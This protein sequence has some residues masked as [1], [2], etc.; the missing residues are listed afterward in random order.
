[1]SFLSVAQEGQKGHIQGFVLVAQSNEKIPFCHIK[2]IESGDQFI[3]DENGFFKT[4]ILSFGEYHFVI[5]NVGY[6]LDTLSILLS[7]P[8]LKHNIE[9]APIFYTIGPHTVVANKQ[10]VGA[11]GR[12]KPIEGVMIAQGKKADVI[13]LSYVAGN[14]ATNNA[15]QIYSSIPGLNIWESDGAGIQLGI[16][17]RGLSPSRTA[18]YN[19]RQNGYD[20]SA[21]A[22]GY[23]ES[24]YTPPSQAI[25]Q[26]QFIK[27]AGSLQYGPQF[28]GV[29]NFKLKKGNRYRPFS[30]SYQKTF[31]SFGVNT[32][33]LEVGGKKKRVQYYG[34]FNWKKGNEWRPNSAYE[35]ITAG[36]NIHYYITENSLINFEFTK[37]SYLAQQPGGLT[38]YEFNTTPFISKRERNWFQVDWNLWSINHKHS[39][40]SKNILNTKV[41]GLIAS[42]KAL[43]FLGQ[44]NRVDPMQ[45]RNLIVGNFNNIGVESKYLKLYDINEIPQALLMGVRLYRGNSTGQQGFGTSS[46]SPDFYFINHTELEF[47]DYSFP[48]KNAAIFVENIFRLNEKTSIV[49]GIRAEWISTKAEGSYNSITYDLADNIIDNTTYYASRE[50]ERSFVIFGIGLDH[51]FKQDTTHLYANFSQNYRSIN[52]TDMQIVNPNFRIDPDLEDERGFNSDIGVKGFINNLLYYDLSVYGLFYNNRIGTT[53]EKDS[54][55]FSTYQY[56]TNISQSLSLGFEGVIQVNWLGSKPETKWKLNTLG[57]YSYTWSRYLDAEGVYAN[58]FVELVPP[59]NWKLITQI[60]YSDLLLS[61]QYSWVHW[62]YSDASNSLSQPN[63]VNGVIPTYDI[64][65]LSLSYSYEELNFRCGMNNLLNEI[66]FTRR[67]TAYPGPGII[68]AAP[69][70]FYFTFGLNF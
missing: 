22:L 37:M 45:E 19:T 52:F 59:V 58:K 7:E 69:R 36:A 17:G 51:A 25:D 49:P 5:S 65:D 47:S 40:N 12:I 31:G 43:G 64:L 33:F 13:N 18:N 28:G 6:G 46:K 42:R 26:V 32:S 15:R 10:H 56:R 34:F 8:I 14:V 57:N 38:D 50:N 16:G 24:Y 35:V 2:I 67:A 60:G 3:S 11:I 41:F 4:P 63:A 9:L 39:F 1:M 20:I 66:Y 29:I 62:Q 48:S 55:L 44:I 70:N 21:D 27:G 68:T 30:G 53:I 54:I 23:P 61:L